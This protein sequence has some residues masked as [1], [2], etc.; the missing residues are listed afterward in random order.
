[1]F[2]GKNPYIKAT[3][4]VRFAYGQRVVEVCRDTD[5]LVLLL[6]CKHQLSSDSTLSA[7]NAVNGCGTV[8]QFVGHSK[9]TAWKAYKLTNLGCCELTEETYSA[10]LRSLSAQYMNH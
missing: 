2:F 4:S 5:V 10:V 6:H 7:I 1:M 8:N 3:G 9:V